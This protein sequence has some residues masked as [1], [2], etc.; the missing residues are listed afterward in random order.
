[1]KKY[2]RCH[3][4]EAKPMTRGDYNKYRGWKIP[5]DE[6]PADEGYHVVYPDGYESWCPKAQFEK[7]SSPEA[8]YEV[9][10]E[11]HDE[12]YAANPEGLTLELVKAY[13]GQFANNPCMTFGQAIEAMKQG[14]KV[15]RRGW[16]GKNMY[17][18][19]MPGSTIKDCPNITDPHLKAISDANGGTVTF[20]GSIRMK[21]ATGEVLTGWLA[22]QTDMLSDDWQII[23]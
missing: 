12:H 13:Y 11:F 10:K 16:N 1:M 9:L 18:W 21:T 5:A 3:I 8:L 4:V 17:V 2:I 19:V 20:T 14:K 23:E 6:N 7:A 15:A 22:S